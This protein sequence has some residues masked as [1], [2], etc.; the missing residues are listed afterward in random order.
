MGTDRRRGRGPVLA[1]LGLLLAVLACPG[2][3]ATA[4][5]VLALTAYRHELAG[6]RGLR[7]SRPRSAPVVL[8]DQRRSVLLFGAVPVLFGVV[9]VVLI[10]LRVVPL[11]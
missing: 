10:V 9:W 11:S 3:A 8:A 7:R 4:R 6:R 1:V 5:I 2:A